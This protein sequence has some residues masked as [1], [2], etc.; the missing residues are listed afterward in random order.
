VGAGGRAPPLVRSVK[1]DYPSRT[2]IM[3]V[4]ICTMWSAS[5]LDSWRPRVLRRQKYTMMPIA[6]TAANWSLGMS[7]ADTDSVAMLPPM[8][9]LTTRLTPPRTNMTELSM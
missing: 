6:S 7:S 9:S 8:A 2:T 3:T 5:L 1:T 4:V